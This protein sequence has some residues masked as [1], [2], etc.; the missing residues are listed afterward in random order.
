MISFVMKS[1]VPEPPLFWAAPAPEVRSPGGDSSSDQIGSAPA[2]A[3]KVAPVP[4]H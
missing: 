1:S 2:Q 3:K 4:Q